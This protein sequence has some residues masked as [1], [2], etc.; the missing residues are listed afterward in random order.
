M[1]YKKTLTIL[2]DYCNKWKLTVNTGKTKIMVFRKGGRL[3]RDL[4]FIYNYSQIEIVNKFCYLGV[5]F[6]AGGSNFE[7]QKTLAGQASKAIFTLNKYLYSFTPL[8]PSHR[9]ELFDKLVS[10][11]LNYAGE[12][13]G[14]HK[15]ST[16]ETVHLQF[17]KKVL[18]VKR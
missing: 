18:G 8:K 10:P 14:F 15:A 16:V 12:V 7:T 17:R 13:W 3:R 5:V 2:E 9:L 4:N 6:T 11:I 1:N